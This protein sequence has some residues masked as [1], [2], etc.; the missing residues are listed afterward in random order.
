VTDPTDLNDVPERPLE[1][2]RQTRRASNLSDHGIQSVRIKLG[3][4]ATIVDA[5]AAGVL[6]DTKQRLLPGTCVELL[7]ETARHRCTIRGRVAR[8]EV[9]LVRAA[10]VLYRGGIAFDQHLPWFSSDDGCALPSS[11]QS[12]PHGRRATTSFRSGP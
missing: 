10:T 1:D 11:E 5:S 7:M 2:R 4:V 3:D 12:D 9:A 6:I 8:C